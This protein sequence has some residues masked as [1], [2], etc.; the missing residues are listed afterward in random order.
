MPAEDIT[1]PARVEV[2]DASYESKLAPSASKSMVSRL[3]KPSSGA[4][5]RARHS[6][7]AT[8]TELICVS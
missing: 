1:S 4:K 5:A 3:S 2:F 7:G 8:L 6:S